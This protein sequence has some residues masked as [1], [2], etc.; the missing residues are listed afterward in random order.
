MSKRKNAH[1]EAVCQLW[2]GQGQEAGTGTGGRDRRL[3]Q[4][5]GQETG[6][7]AGTGGREMTVLIRR[8]CAKRRS[9]GHPATWSGG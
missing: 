9:R 5:Q 4:G 2:Q 7:G 3:G 8:I 1:A 6:T